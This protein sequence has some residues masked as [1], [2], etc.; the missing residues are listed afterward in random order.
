MQSLCVLPLLLVSTVLFDG[1][2]FSDVSPSCIHICTCATIVC[3][4]PRRLGFYAY[5]CLLWS[6]VKRSKPIREEGCE[7]NF[8]HSSAAALK[9]LQPFKA[10][11][12]F[13]TDR[14]TSPQGQTYPEQSFLKRRTRDS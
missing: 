3:L 14:C 4:R 5:C 1:V 8:A 9:A 7:S 13:F 6:L 10:V 11:K 12:S 2:A